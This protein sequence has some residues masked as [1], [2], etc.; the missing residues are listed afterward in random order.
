M[1]YAVNLL[2][3]IKRDLDMKKI[4]LI[5]VAAAIVSGCASGGY[6]DPYANLRST[7]M[8]TVES[9]SRSVKLALSNGTPDQVIAKAKAAV[10]D[11]LKDPGS[12]QFRN[13]AIVNYLGGQVVCGEV[14]G[15]NS[16]G[17]YVGFVPFVASTE[18]SRLFD[19]DDKYPAIQ[20]AVNSGLEAACSG[21]KYQHPISAEST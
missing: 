2:T 8:T 3:T 14:N 18:S 7:A 17:G 1:L 20:S 13:V 15:K 5:T 9:F 10:A 11:G 6:V 12:A 4:A 16:Y 19:K 21:S